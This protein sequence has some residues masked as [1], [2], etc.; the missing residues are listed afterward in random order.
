MSKIIILSFRMGILYLGRVNEEVYNMFILYTHILKNDCKPSLLLDIQV[1]AQL[2]AL[3]SI[4]QCK[5][6]SLILEEFFPSNWQFST[7]S[8]DPGLVITCS[9]KFFLN[10]P[11]LSCPLSTKETSF[12]SKICAYIFY[13]ITHS[14]C[15]I[16]S[17]IP[18]FLH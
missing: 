12:T 10:N 15:Y 6:C 1:P 14:F 11:T 7:N 3:C 17:F 16:V 13:S 4:L 9:S 8:L 2:Q 18:C 5:C